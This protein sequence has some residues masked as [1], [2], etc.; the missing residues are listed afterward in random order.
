MKTFELLHFGMNTMRMD[1][2]LLQTFIDNGHSFFIAVVY[3]LY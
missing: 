1:S 3:P 2:P